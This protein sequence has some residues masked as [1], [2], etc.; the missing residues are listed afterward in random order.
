MLVTESDILVTFLEIAVEQVRINSILVG[1]SMS[2][3]FEKVISAAKIRKTL[4]GWHFINNEYS[5]FSIRY[6]FYTFP[7]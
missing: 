4:R 2:N 5:K 1:T 3:N 7:L 6:D